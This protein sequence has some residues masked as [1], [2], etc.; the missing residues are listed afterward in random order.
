MDKNASSSI[1]FSYCCSVN[2]Q[3]IDGNALKNLCRV[4]HVSWFVAWKIL[5]LLT[6]RGERNLPEEF[7]ADERQ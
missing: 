7:Y 1:S 6:K 3:R 4:A 2:C 5:A